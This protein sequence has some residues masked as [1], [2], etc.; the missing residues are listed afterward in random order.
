MTTSLALTEI[1]G[2]RYEINTKN[3][4]IAQRTGPT[5]PAP[6]Q[7][8]DQWGGQIEFLLACLGNAVGLGNCWRFPYL[9]YKNGGVAVYYNMIIAWTL[10]YFVGSFLGQDWQHCGQHFNTL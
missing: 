5:A 10:F 2:N 9:C 6:K 3:G 7:T 8:R 1:N 4:N